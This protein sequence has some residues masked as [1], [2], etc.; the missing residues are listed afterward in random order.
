M[1]QYKGYEVRPHINSPKHLI[2][3]TPGK[4]GKIP[5]LLQGMFTD[6]R[7][8]KEAIDIYTENKGA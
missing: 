5:N 1:I 7:T 6:Y 4:A 2:I 8:A 3:V